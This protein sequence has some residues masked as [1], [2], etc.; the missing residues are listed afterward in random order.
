MNDMI[1]APGTVDNI[2]RIANTLIEDPLRTKATKPIRHNQIA[3]VEAA[4]TRPALPASDDDDPDE[5]WDNFP[6]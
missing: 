2:D 6:V 1:E 3:P 4:R 5:F